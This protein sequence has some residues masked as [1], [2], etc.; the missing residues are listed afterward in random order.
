MRQNLKSA[1]SI[2]FYCGKCFTALLAFVL[3]ACAFANFVHIYG[4]SAAHATKAVPQGSFYFTKEYL[5]LDFYIFF[6]VF[7]V[8]LFVFIFNTYFYLRILMFV[9]GLSAGSLLAYTVGDLFT[10][11]LFIF[12]AWILMLCATL[13]F[14]YNILLAGLSG[15]CFT[16]L[17]Y[18]PASLG[19][20]DSATAANIPQ[21]QDI[22][23]LVIYF[24]LT[25]LI[26]V[27]Y[28]YVVQKWAESVEYG[29]HLNNVM[30]QM[31]VFNQQLQNVAKTRGDDAAKQERLRITRDMHDSCGYV[32]VNI[33]SLID[34]AES[35][36]DFSREQMDETLMTVRTL[37]SN[38]L[39]ETRRTLHAIRD[40][41]DPVE[42]NIDAIY[43]IKKLF[44]QVTG[45]HVT[46]NPGNVKHDYGHTVNS[47]IIRT[48]QEALTNAIRHGRAQ[49][50][51]ITFWE[52][53]GILTM[54]V[55]DDCIGS[56]Q[57]VKGIGLA[58]M[59]ERLEKVGGTLL[60]DSP[61]DGGFRLTVTIPLTEALS[62]IGVTQNDKAQNTA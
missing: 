31:S 27:A 28:K 55:K 3:V 54:A 41:Q 20:V 32:F 37:A 6:A 17:Q 23:T 10:I 16:L 9:L 15:T 30:T 61:K 58:G 56:K 24:L 29:Q 52:E 19:I 2:I 21:K 13:P 42:K 1:D 14:F 36:P 18:Y 50:M 4:I 26:S 53:N 44:E 59:E 49:N 34:A 7:T 38:G 51:F 22:F 39:Q 40:M 48:M 46:V 45:I 33:T 11:K 62:Q 47:I 25:M 8:S 5:Y 35:R 57:T 60:T 12:C 43:D